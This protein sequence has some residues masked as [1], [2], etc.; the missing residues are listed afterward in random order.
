[1]Q[2]YFEEMETTMDSKEEML[3]HLQRQNQ[4]LSRKLS[5]SQIEADSRVT[6]LE[7]QLRCTTLAACC[8]AAGV[9]GCSY[10]SG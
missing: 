1:M 9:L 4:V 3:T 5:Q 2:E 7:Q 10:W 6:D 8:R